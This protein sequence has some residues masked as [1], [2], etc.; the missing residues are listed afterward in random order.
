MSETG[1][2][3]WRFDVSAFRLIGRDLIT[4]RVTAVYELVKNCYD[5]NATSVEVVLDQVSSLSSQS[6][7]IIKDDG[8]GMSFEDIR[9]KWMVIGTS[10]KRRQPYSPLPFNRKCVGEKGI[11]RF[12]VDKLG[13]LVTI[14]T[15]KA[16]TK[17]WLSVTINWADYFS[18][19]EKKKY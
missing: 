6:K 14:K 9:D 8:Y 16:N 11:G 17:S 4:D 15:K 1:S 10:S 5:A 2:L 19:L 18:G 12:A 13:D 7:I 3:K